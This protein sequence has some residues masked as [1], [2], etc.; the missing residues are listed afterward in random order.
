MSRDGDSHALS[1]VHVHIDTK[2]VNIG[3]PTNCRI[4]I[5]RIDHKYQ[6][7]IQDVT[8]D[9]T[10]YNIREGRNSL[11][12][13]EYVTTDTNTPTNS[14]VLTL[15]EGNYSISDIVAAINDALA[16][17]EATPTTPYEGP[18][19]TLSKKFKYG[20]TGNHSISYNNINGL[21]SFSV[22]QNTNMLEIL[23]NSNQET[24]LLSILGFSAPI[25]FS[26]PVSGDKLA[27]VYPHPYVFVLSDALTKYGSRSY[28][29]FQYANN[30]QQFDNVI[31][32]IPLANNSFGD[33]IYF[34][35]NRTFQYDPEQEN[36]EID[37]Q[38][39]HQN[40]EIVNLHG[41][42]LKLTLSFV[43]TNNPVINI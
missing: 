38:V 22:N 13:N 1:S 15:K 39:V 19:Y 14:V 5:P 26:T 29:L 37:L 31:C 36:A 32:C 34:N 43:G 28:A 7:I 6:F 41:G 4:R 30:F 25:K 18:N 33:R 11:I 2:Y 3:N 24:T 10:F 27:D 21:I 16:Q 23:P 42:S 40:G 17:K 35:D 20:G 9:F 12:I 8:L